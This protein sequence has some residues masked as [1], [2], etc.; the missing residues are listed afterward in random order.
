MFAVTEVADEGDDVE[1]ELVVREGQAALGLGPVGLTNRRA[2]VVAAATDGE[3]ESRDASESGEGA[4]IGVVG[5]EVATA[6]QAGG[7]LG[8]QVVS[9]GRGQLFG[10]LAHRSVLRDGPNPNASTTS[11]ASHVCGCRKKSRSGR[12]SRTGRTWPP[13]GPTG[14]SK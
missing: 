12:P 13:P 7:P 8:H 11:D 6:V 14:G 1:P 9:D 3:V 4:P 10:G 5:A 2:V